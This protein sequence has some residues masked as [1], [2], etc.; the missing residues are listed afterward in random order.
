MV[1]IQGLSNTHIYFP[2]PLHHPVL[3][4]PNHH[5]CLV[6]IEYVLLCTNK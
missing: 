4:G 2:D 5:T 6:T 1:V 3:L